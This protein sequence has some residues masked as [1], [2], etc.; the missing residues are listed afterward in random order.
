MVCLLL[1]ARKSET[2]TDQYRCIYALN[3]HCYCSNCNPSIKECRQSSIFSI[4]QCYM[5]IQTTV[6]LKSDVLNIFL[7]LN[8]HVQNDVRNVNLFCFGLTE[9]HKSVVTFYCSP[10]KK[11]VNNVGLLFPVFERSLSDFRENFFHGLVLL[12]GTFHV[13]YSSYGLSQ[14]LS[15]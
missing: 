3:Y 12:D 15:F 1:H 6:H 10:A 4:S 2:M 8:A 13:C 11:F 7:A 9:F 5:P 14:T